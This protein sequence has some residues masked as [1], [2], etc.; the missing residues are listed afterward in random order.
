M[1]VLAT[2]TLIAGACLS[3]MVNQRVRDTVGRHARFARVNH[4]VRPQP[5]A[6]PFTHQAVPPRV[7]VIGK[8]Y[9]RRGVR[10][11]ASEGKEEVDSK[12]ALIQQMKEVQSD[13]ELNAL[14]DANVILID[15]HFWLKINS[16][17]K[18]APN[19]HEKNRLDSVAQKVWE[20][21]ENLNK[22]QEGED[23]SGLEEYYAILGSPD[24]DI[25]ELSPEEI[26]EK[27]AKKWLN[28]QRSEMW[29]NFRT[30]QKH[31]VGVWYGNWEVYDD[32][33]GGSRNIE[34]TSTGSVQCS[35][36]GL[37][38]DVEGV[39][40]CQHLQRISEPNGVVPIPQDLTERGLNFWPLSP[41]T[42]LVANVFSTG[43]RILD[44]E[45]DTLSME[46]AV[47]CDDVRMRVI[48]KYQPLGLQ[49]DDKDTFALAS[50]S[51]G[52]EKVL[53]LPNGT[54]PA[55][56]QGNDMLN[57]HTALLFQESS[58]ANVSL[59][60]R[61]NLIVQAP[62]VIRSGDEN[63]VQVSWKMPPSEAQSD[64]LSEI[65][66]EAYSQ[67]VSQKGLVVTTKRVFSKLDGAAE[68]ISLKEELPE[69]W[70]QEY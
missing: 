68:Y 62:R 13:E 50:I 60:V 70:Q 41:K 35:V 17:A 64:E 38:E 54:E 11:R 6:L 5:Y 65:Y 2:F 53:E 30:F 18:K 56:Y 9:R 8:R 46:A 34:P 10:G 23:V 31:H 40:V 7:M 48:T 61:G 33:L 15:T 29:R 52:R 20:R 21:M 66:G 24:E 59:A 1:A 49:S 69:D 55:L 32:I 22:A 39:Q 28:Q 42:W 14:V 12:L 67:Q 4:P 51:I 47:R 45:I 26:L 36:E 19:P 27:R 25:Q 63:Y 43:D 37:L 16:L 3:A 57:S 44:N 58:S